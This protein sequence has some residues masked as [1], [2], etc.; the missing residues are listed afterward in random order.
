MAFCD[1]KTLVAM[2]ASQDHKRLQDHD[3]GPNTGGM[4]AYAPA[5]MVSPSLTDRLEEE[6]FQPFLKGIA[7]EG[8]DYRGIIY[9]GLMITPSGPRVLEFNVRFGDPETQA[10]LPLLES[11]L[12]D[13]LLAVAERR[14]ASPARPLKEKETFPVR[15]AC[16]RGLPRGL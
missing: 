10:V 15:G 4:G 7:A 5:P 1:G 6:I 16:L 3:E 8:F 9:F 13:V 11:D 12:I 2:P 14:L